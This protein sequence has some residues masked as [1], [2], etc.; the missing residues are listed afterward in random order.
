LCEDPAL[1]RARLA[2]TAAVQAALATGLGLI[3]I[4]APDQM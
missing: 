3:G 2:L 1:R 4:A